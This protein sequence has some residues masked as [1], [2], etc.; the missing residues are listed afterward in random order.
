MFKKKGVRI[1]LIVFGVVVLLLGGGLAYYRFS[2]IQGTAEAYAVNEKLENEPGITQVLVYTQDRKFKNE[3]IENIVKDVSAR[4]IYLEVNPIEELDKSE[5]LS[6]WDK[7]ILLTTVESSDPPR[8]ALDFI[9]ENKD[10]NKVATFLTADSGA[11]AHQPDDVDVLTG[12]SF[13][14]ETLDTFT[15]EILDFIEVK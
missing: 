6:K 11:W 8:N 3:V 4:E 5:D 7:I 15:D 9:N 12:A 14:A 13:K 2:R 1:A 10:N